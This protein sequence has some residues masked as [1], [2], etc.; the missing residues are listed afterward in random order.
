MKKEKSESD[1]EKLD[2]TKMI[3]TD[4]DNNI[5]GKFNDALKLNEKSNSEVGKKTEGMDEDNKTGASKKKSI[6]DSKSD[7]VGEEMGSL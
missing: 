2:K 4:Q 3:G 5:V 1:E 7:K 6:L